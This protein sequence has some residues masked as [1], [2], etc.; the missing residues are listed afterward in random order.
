MGL[1]QS[2]EHGQVVDRSH[3][4]QVMLQTGQEIG[5]CVQSH[6]STRSACQWRN[7][8]D[9]PEVYKYPSHVIVQLIGNAQA[10]R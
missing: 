8:D 3:S 9:G 10:D 1:G 5:H 7:R 2:R 6:V 4:E